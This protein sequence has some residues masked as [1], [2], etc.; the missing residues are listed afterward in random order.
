M[1][2]I[3]RRAGVNKQLLFYYFGSKAGLYRAALDIAATEMSDAPA[4]A[5][6]SLRDTLTTAF[7][8][9]IDH[10]EHVSLIVHAAHSRE[11]LAP[12]VV[13][14]ASQPWRQVRN[15][16]S[17][18]QGVGLVRDDVDPDTLAQQAVVLLVGF[19]ALEPVLRDLPGGVAR[20]GWAAAVA[21]SF[22]RILA[23]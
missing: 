1:E 17:A 4:G 15:A 2:R 11:R 22:T 13:R 16:I 20:E 8:Y 7:Q 6:A 12:S 9:L 10:P 23:W 3:A 21:D 19:L 18:G 14:A 5:A